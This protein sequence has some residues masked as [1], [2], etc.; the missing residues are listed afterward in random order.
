LQPEIWALI[1]GGLVVLVILIGLIA[2][3]RGKEQEQLE[4]KV[5][6]S[7]TFRVVVV[8][9]LL[10]SMVGFAVA[11]SQSVTVDWIFGRTNV[12]LVV[13]IGSSGFVGLLL[14]ALIA[15]RKKAE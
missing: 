14:G 11:N 12:P 6:R 1:A 8:V 7:Q 9:L 3:R 13:V 5:R 15:Y 2:S 4:R 10:T